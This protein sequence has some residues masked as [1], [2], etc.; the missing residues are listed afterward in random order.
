MKVP[1]FNKFLVK[2]TIKKLGYAGFI[3]AYSEMGE[4]YDVDNGKNFSTAEDEVNDVIKQ[5]PELEKVKKELIEITRNMRI[6][7]GLSA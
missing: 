5:V 3:K 7:K 4:A 1:V 6:K 2:K